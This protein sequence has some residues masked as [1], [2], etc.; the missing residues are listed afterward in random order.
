[1]ILFN[2]LVG[3]VF[4]AGSVTSERERQTLDLLLTTTISPWTILWGKLISG[5]RV[6][7]VLTMFLLWP[8]LLACV[9]PVGYW[10]SLP[11]MFGYLVIV[12]LSCLTTS[13]IALFCSVLVRKTSVSLIWTYLT[14]V[15][16][17]AGPLAA[18]FFASTFFANSPSAT[19]IQSLGF[20]SPLA[21]T[22]SLPLDLESREQTPIRSN[23]P[24]FF[25][26]LAFATV[27]NLG[28]LAAMAWLFNVRWRVAQ[29]GEG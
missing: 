26:Y 24:L 20:T 29:S 5:L 15:V 3:P 8:V 19:R 11:T 10:R 2:M 17:F 14:I 16:L 25:S 12:L 27:S 7:S 22:F 9:M 4:S 23:L 13:I 6:S 28:L 18:S 1:V 21:A